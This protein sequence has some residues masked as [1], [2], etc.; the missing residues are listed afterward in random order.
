MLYW[1]ALSRNAGRVV[2]SGDQIEQVM[3]G[4]SL[5]P[6][7]AASDVLIRDG[8]YVWMMAASKNKRFVVQL[9]VYVWLKI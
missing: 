4:V 6:Y 5:S 8:L 1:R 3:K 2:F 9:H 7:K